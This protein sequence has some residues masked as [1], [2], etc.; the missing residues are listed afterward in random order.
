MMRINFRSRF[1]I[2]AAICALIIA[3]AYAV[4]V[5]QKKEP[6]APQPSPSPLVSPPLTQEHIGYSTQGRAINAY[7]FGHGSQQLLFVGGVHGGYEWNSVLLAYEF[8]DYIKEH[9]S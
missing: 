6:Q 4:F 5:L 8:I 9:P 1:F 2:I 3:G 7:T